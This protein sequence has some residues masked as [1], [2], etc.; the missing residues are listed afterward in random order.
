M[1]QGLVAIALLLTSVSAVPPAAHSQAT[2]FND[3]RKLIQ[4]GLARDSAPGLAIAVARGDS[5]LWM[6]GFGWADP[7]KRIPVTVNTPF[8][9]ASTT[10]TIT[11]TAVMILRER[12]RLDLNR[13]ANDYLRA[14]KL[15]SPRWTT[16]DATVRHLATH[17]SGITTFDLGCPSSTPNCPFP[18]MDELIRRYGVVSR[19]PGEYFDYS[20]LGYDILGE[21]VAHAAGKDLGAFMRDEIFKPLGMTHS[22][23]GVDTAAAPAPAVPYYWVR[24]RVPHPL[25]KLAASSGYSSVHDLVRFGQ[26]HL[27]LRPPGARAILSRAAID[28]MQLSDVPATSTQRYGIGWWIDENR[29]GYRSVLAQGGTPGSAAWL[30]LIPSEQIVVVLL[31]NKGVSFARAVVDAAIAELLPRYAALMN[32]TQPAQASNASTPAP[33][34]L[35]TSFVGGWTGEV[36]TESGEVKMQLTVSDSGAVLA[37]LSSRPG[38]SPGRARFSGRLFRLNITGDLATTDSTRGQRMFF[39][40]RPGDGVMNGAVTLGAGTGTLSGLEGR[41]SY[42]VELRRPR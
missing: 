26:M 35:D 40:L 41:V 3:V 20:N 33:A 30:R 34:A 13:P 31:A 9:L 32:A 15:W 42:W 17:R 25:Q 36:L 37:T 8:Y 14:A 19:P 39:Y 4:D 27:K 7:E 1:R 21:V 2:R 29:F 6:E 23:L 22:T 18:S 16:A 5:I 24:G 10:K 12:G 28:T 11:A 38:A